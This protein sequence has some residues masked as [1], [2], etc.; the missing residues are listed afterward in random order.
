VLFSTTATP[1]FFLSNLWVSQQRLANIFSF[2]S[3]CGSARKYVAFIGENQ[4]LFVILIVKRARA[5][6][7]PFAGITQLNKSSPY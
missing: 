6:L 2:A 5:A 1:Y 7:P 4:K 3:F